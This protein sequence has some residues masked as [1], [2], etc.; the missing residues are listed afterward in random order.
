MYTAYRNVYGVLLHAGAVETEFSLVRFGDEA[1]AKRFY[2]DF[3]PLIGE[4]V[5]DNVIYV[6][7]R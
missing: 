7:T 5:A 2:S 4:D 6:A 3:V 1:K